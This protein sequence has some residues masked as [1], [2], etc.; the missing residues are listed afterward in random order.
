MVVAIDSVHGGGRRNVFGL[1][2]ISV[3]PKLTDM[4]REWSYSTQFR[5]HLELDG[6][7]KLVQFSFWTDWV[8]GEA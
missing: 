3:G 2:L 4:I 8:V 5:S 6:V 1:T 7:H